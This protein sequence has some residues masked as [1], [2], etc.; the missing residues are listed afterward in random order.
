MIRYQLALLG[1]S[2]RYVPPVLLYLVVVAMLYDDGVAPA[3]P[4]FA[5]T[6]AILAVVAC[7]LTVALVDAED[8]V[9]RLVTASAARR[10]AAPVVGVAA[11]VLVCCV[12]LA[13]VSAAW[14]LVRRE[15]VTWPVAGFGALAHVACAAVGVAVGLPSSRLLVPR[16][17]YSVL[18]A[19]AALLV[20]LLVRQVPLVN[21]MLRELGGNADPAGSVLVGLAASAVAL[22]LSVLAV[23]VVSHRRG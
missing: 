13:A 22:V 5:V 18:V 10:G 2:Q 17:G 12:A 15:G 23:T 19:L 9:Q 16:R 7:W 14:M 4:E 1:H 20:V 8:P 3:L 11:A 6:A 21:P